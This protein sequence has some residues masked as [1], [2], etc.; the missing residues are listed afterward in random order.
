MQESELNRIL[1]HALQ[2]QMA[3]RCHRAYRHDLRNGLQG[4][5]GG[6]DALSRLLRLPNTDTTRVE[7]TTD[8]V[9]QAITG[10]EKSLD[11][12]LHALSPLEQAPE[13]ADASLLLQE[14][15]KFL[16]NDAAAKRVTLRNAAQPV[17]I[18]VRTDKLRLVLLSLMVDAID[19][20]PGGGTLQI[21]CN[22]VEGAAVIEFADTRAE[23]LPE[24]PWRLDFTAAPAYRGWTLPVAR[25]LILAEA[26]TIDCVAGPSG[27][28][29]VRIALPAASSQ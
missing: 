27:G 14:L 10:H 21:S 25:Q 26:G 11:R 19:A 29:S 15:L 18:H 17:T 6:F 5:Y 4:I 9:R 28:R 22:S 16:T 12:V 23:L 24:D 8:L 1:E 7:R 13:P 20:M 3:S 2:A